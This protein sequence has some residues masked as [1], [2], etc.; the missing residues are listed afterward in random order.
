[1]NITYIEPSSYIGDSLKDINHNFYE[2]DRNI[3][4]IEQQT[5]KFS[6]LFKDYFNN[7]FANFINASNSLSANKDKFQ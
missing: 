4:E 3:H 1:M 6:H 2:I 7:S 5:L